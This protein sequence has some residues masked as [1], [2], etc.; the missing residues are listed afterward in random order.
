MVDFTD[1]KSPVS[2][3]ASFPKPSSAHASREI[4]AEDTSI[5][6]MAKE[7]LTPDSS[8]I[9]SVK[10]PSYEC[11]IRT[12]TSTDAAVMQIFIRATTW[13]QAGAQKA[14]SLLSTTTG[15]SSAFQFAGLAGCGLA[16][17]TFS[18]V[19]VRAFAD[20]VKLL[21]AGK[22]SEGG[23]K[24]FGASGAGASALSALDATFKVIQH[25]WTQVNLAFLG[26]VGGALCAGIGPIVVATVDAIALMKLSKSGKE[27]FADI[28]LL[29][30]FPKEKASLSKEEKIKYEA[31]LN[32]TPDE[33]AN[34]LAMLKLDLNINQRDKYIKTMKI[35]GSVAFAALQVTLAIVTGG[36]SLGV[37]MAFTVTYLAVSYSIEWF[38]ANKAKAEEAVLKQA[39]ATTLNSRYEPHHF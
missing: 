5:G 2:G 3:H 22:M 31:L 13:I 25:F 10:K 19:T 16:A 7:R 26:T 20:G 11:S 4:S 35:L 1:P 17:L 32:L 39:Y 14:T 33:R 34:K 30:S 8:S 36:M 12:K 28:Q 6:G 15:T 38:C 21:L 9:S 24:L 27:I 29:E 23:L 18:Y 37:M